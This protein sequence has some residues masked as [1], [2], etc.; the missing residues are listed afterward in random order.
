MSD[1]RAT[2]ASY[3]CVPT[4]TH[5]LKF[6][7]SLKQNTPLFYVVHNKIVMFCYNK[8]YILANSYEYSAYFKY[9]VTSSLAE[10]H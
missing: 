6:T 8:S 5:P 9:V 3:Q 1:V 10:Q 7:F 2:V 4:Q